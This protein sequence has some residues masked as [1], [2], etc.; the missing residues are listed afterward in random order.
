MAFASAIV[1][2]HLAAVQTTADIT[3]PFVG[4]VPAAS[5][6][7]AFG[8]ANA[9]IIAGQT[10]AGMA[11]DGID[12]IPREGTWLLDGGERVLNPNQ[13]KDLTNYLARGGSDGDITIQVNVT[14]S[15]VSSSGGNTQEQK[16]LGQM[17]GN[18]V[19]A[20]IRQE[21]RQGGL[22]SK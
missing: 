16:Q 14:D 11:H 8:Y 12:N 18:A 13:N 19:R 21:Q 4:K 7:L 5:A 2:A 3:L 10:I 17:I 22:L 20:V 15:G 6:I 9:G 1:S